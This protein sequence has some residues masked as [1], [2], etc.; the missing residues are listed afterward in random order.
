MNTSEDIRNDTLEGIIEL[1][2]ASAETKGGPGNS[3][4]GGLGKGVIPGIS[5]E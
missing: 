5:E 3:E 1:G 2:I 4:G